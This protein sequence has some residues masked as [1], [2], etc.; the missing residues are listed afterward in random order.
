MSV[1]SWSSSWNETSSRRETMTTERFRRVELLKL[2]IV[3]YLQDMHESLTGSFPAPESWWEATDSIVFRLAVDLV[4]LKK[5]SAASSSADEPDRKQ[6]EPRGETS[7]QQQET[8]GSNALWYLQTVYVA[9]PATSLSSNSVLDLV[10]LWEQLADSQFVF[11][12]RW[13]CLNFFSKTTDCSF[14]QT[15]PGPQNR[16]SEQNNRTTTRSGSHILNWTLQVTE[17]LFSSVLLILILV[18]SVLNTA[19]SDAPWPHPDSRPIRFV[20][21]DQNWKGACPKRSDWVFRVQTTKCGSAK[22]R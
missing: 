1:D 20:C 22:D 15:G 14:N 5:Q 3:K 2:M 6:P 12:S 9:D 4:E 7:E 19:G 18:L 13:Y 11:L 16:M 17:V 21:S 10:L 8:E